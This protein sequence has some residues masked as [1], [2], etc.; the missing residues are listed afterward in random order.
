MQ[1]AFC[2]RCRFLVARCR[3]SGRGQRAGFRKQGLPFCLEGLLRGS[4]LGL[5]FIERGAALGNRQFELALR[6]FLCFEPCLQIKPLTVDPFIP[7]ERVY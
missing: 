3:L 5:A 4:Q 2:R 6:G 7:K 1:F